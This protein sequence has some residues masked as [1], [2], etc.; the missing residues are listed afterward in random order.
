MNKDDAQYEKAKEERTSIQTELFLAIRSVYARLLY[1]LGDPATG[2]SKLADTTLLDSYVEKPGDEP[3]KYDGKDNA[4]KGELVV[5]NTLR[6][7][8]K[9]SCAVG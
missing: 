3:I 2:E 8:A 5:E 4:S 6:T 9:S 1:P 7:V